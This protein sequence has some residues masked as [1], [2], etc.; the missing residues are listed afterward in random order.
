MMHNIIVKQ[1]RKAR[2]SAMDYFILKHTP[3]VITNEIYCNFVN[4]C[5]IMP[6]DFEKLLADGMLELGEN[7]SWIKTD[8]A[9]EATRIVMSYTM[10]RNAGNFEEFW[11]AYPASDKWGSW[12]RTRVL[13]AEKKRCGILYRKAL[14]N[15]SH[16]DLIRAMEWEVKMRK[17]TSSTENRMSY[18]PALA[19]W[20]NGGYYETNLEEMKESQNNESTKRYGGDIE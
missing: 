9:K 14:K 19:R 8:K 18:M 5:N 15:C 6:E 1:L 3:D 17:S 12:P 2:I 11:K 13:R 20:L 10:D 7:E 16:H 4:Y